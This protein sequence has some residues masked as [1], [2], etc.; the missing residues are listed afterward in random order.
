[1]LLRFLLVGLGFALEEYVTVFNLALE[2]AKQTLTQ[3][4]QEPDGITEETL[5]ADITAESG[6]TREQVEGFIG[7]DFDWGAVAKELK[8]FAQNPDSINQVNLVA[9][10]T[11]SSGGKISD[12]DAASLDLTQTQAILEEISQDA[13]ANKAK[14]HDDDLVVNKK[15]KGVELLSVSRKTTLVSLVWFF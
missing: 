14:T 12:E 6:M 5:M 3:R 8:K 9:F 11:N 15:E 13:L 2:G 7:D 4:F 1:M 10:I